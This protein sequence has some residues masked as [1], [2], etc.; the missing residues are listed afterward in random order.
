MGN[1]AVD[2]ALEWLEKED[3][4]LTQKILDFVGKHFDWHPDR[5]SAA[6]Y[7]DAAVNVFR[8]LGPEAR[9][10][11]PKLV[12]LAQSHPRTTV[13]IRAISALGEL[14][15][16]ADETVPSL[17]LC[18]DDA[19]PKLRMEAALSLGSIGRQPAVVVPRLLACL[20]DT[21]RFDVP[22]FLYAFLGFTNESARVVPALEFHLQR[23]NTAQAAANVILH[24]GPAADWPLARALTHPEAKVRVAAAA[25]LMQTQRR[26]SRLLPST[27][28]RLRVRSNL[29]NMTLQMVA[30]NDRSSF[31]VARAL[32]LNLDHPNP[33]L[34]HYFA[35]LLI[36]H[37]E[38]A[39][40][41]L[42]EVIQALSSDDIYVA[43]RAWMVLD[44][45]PLDE[46]EFA[47][48]SPRGRR[49]QR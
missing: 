43:F 8:I 44:L 18:L 26:R 2:A 42:P 14:G 34:R 45:M 37:S 19:D 31:M 33:E 32:A 23:A 47:S 6:H 24:F 41:A 1:R 30:A 38:E 49:S 15:P 25:A 27:G 17:L 3:G 12:S 11:V 29:Q 10:A 36:E 21:N 9:P 13:R 16:M 28:E 39:V 48:P 22:I 4:R 40:I 7:H 5:R 35:D 46:V 20:E